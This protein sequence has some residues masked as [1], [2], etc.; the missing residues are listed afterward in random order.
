M[1]SPAK[2]PKGLASPFQSILSCLGFIQNGNDD[3]KRVNNQCNV[4]TVCL[5]CTTKS[6][7]PVASAVHTDHGNKEKRIVTGH[8][9]KE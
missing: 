1:R 7:G 6:R 8:L 9:R 4:E 2:L 5:R 3:F